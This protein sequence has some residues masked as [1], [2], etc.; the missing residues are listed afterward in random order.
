MSPPSVATIMSAVPVPA[1]TCPI[2]S[3]LIPITFPFPAVIVRGTGTPTPAPASPEPAVPSKELPPEL[4]PNH[5]DVHEVAIP[6][7]VAIVLLKLAAGC[8]AEIG[9]GGKVGDYGTAGVEAA[10]EGLEGGGSMVLLLELD[11]DVADHMVGEVVADVEALD[12]AELAKLLEEVLIE[13][14]EMVLNLAGIDGLPL[15]IDAGGDHVGTLVHVG[16]DEGGGDGG[17][18]MEAGA[19]VP[20]AAS[21][22]LEV[23]RAVHPVL[24]GTEDGS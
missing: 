5:L 4:P 17:S 16:E 21:S 1:T 18:V 15:G 11:I 3:I 20:V 13:V 23:E 8:L 9:D 14:L 19:A 24:L 22:D 7:A 2:I 12:L 6:S 10:M